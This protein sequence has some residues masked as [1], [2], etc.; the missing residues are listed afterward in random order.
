MCAAHYNYKHA[1]EIA[2]HSLWLYVCNREMNCC[3]VYMKFELY[4][5]L[6][7]SLLFWRCFFLT[8]QN[9]KLIHISFFIRFQQATINSGRG[10]IKLRYCICKFVT[11]SRDIFKF[12]AIPHN[13][14]KLEEKKW[15][16]PTNGSSRYINRALCI[17][18]ALYIYAGGTRCIL[19]LYIQFAPG[20]TFRKSL[21]ALWFAAAPRA[22]SD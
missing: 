2:V 19:H 18:R 5:D 22:K 4:R 15:I 10:E 12:R 17:V 9:W 7:K 3:C 11:N 14:V 21:S 1:G 20:D 8:N 6:I 16:C 13:Q